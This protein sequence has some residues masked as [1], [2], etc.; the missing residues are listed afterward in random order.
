ME[1]IREEVRCWQPLQ[2]QPS[3]SWGAWV[4]PK[5]VMM[6]QGPVGKSPAQTQRAD[7]LPSSDHLP[8]FD[9]EDR[10]AQ[11]GPPLCGQ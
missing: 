7:F 5:K 1:H 10:M 2:V 4:Q 11:V 8:L 9:N 6:E 3:G